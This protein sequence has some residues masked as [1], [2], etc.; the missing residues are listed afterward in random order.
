MSKQFIVDR[1]TTPGTPALDPV[2]TPKVPVYDTLEDVE[3]DLANLSEGQIVA[4][5][6]DGSEL[7]MP[8]DVVEE[9]NMHAV[10]SNAVAAVYPDY[11]RKILISDSTSRY[12]S[13]Y[14]APHN[15]YLYAGGY[16]N[17]QGNS[18]II[19]VVG[20]ITFKAQGTTE[21]NDCWLMIPLKKGTTVNIDVRLTS[22]NH[23]IYFIY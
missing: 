21:G 20:G 1:H 19:F 15:G 6:G 9:G 4:T 22:V 3:A 23:G 2:A 11:T 12:Q 10:T 16:G 14:V 8:V 7:P 13:N 18:T 5:G 17:T